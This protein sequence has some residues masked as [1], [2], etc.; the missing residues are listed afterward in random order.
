VN[1]HVD[2]SVDVTISVDQQVKLVI[3]GR[4]PLGN[5]DLDF[6]ATHLIGTDFGKS[7]GNHGDPLV[8]RRSRIGAH[9]QPV[10]DGDL[11]DQLKNGARD[12]TG[13]A[14][15]KVRAAGLVGQVLETRLRV[16]TPGFEFAGT[17]IQNENGDPVTHQL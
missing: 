2:Q 3:S 14:E 12:L 8:I 9:R 1:D 5:G 10:D 7:I 17:S 15:E 6:E 4:H 16:C 11:T 13:L